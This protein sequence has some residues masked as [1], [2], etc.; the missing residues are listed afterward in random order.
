MGP[1]VVVHDFAENSGAF[2]ESKDLLE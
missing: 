1:T 2:I